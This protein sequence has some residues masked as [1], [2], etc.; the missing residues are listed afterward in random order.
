MKI[1][2]N[3]KLDSSKR[4]CFSDLSNMDIKNIPKIIDSTLKKVKIE[5]VSFEIVANSRVNISCEEIYKNIEKGIEQD[6]GFLD[7]LLL[8]R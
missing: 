1:N 6:K 8:L 3:E 7:P 2:V 4:I 5:I